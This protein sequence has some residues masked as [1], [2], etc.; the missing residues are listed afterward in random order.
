MLLSVILPIYNVKPY[1]AQCLNSFLREQPLLQE[2]GE[3]LLIDD[4]STDDSGE[5][6]ESYARKYPF[7]RVFHQPN[8]GAAAARNL[9]MR[10]ARGDWLWFVDA[11][12]WIAENGVA[13]I[14]NAAAA[15]PKAD[16]ILF[17]AFQNR[18]KQEKVWEHFAKPALFRTRHNMEILQRMVLYP[19]SRVSM[20]APW[21]KIYR[22]SFLIKNRLSFP[23]ELKVLDD[24]AFNARVFG[25]AETAAYCKRRIYHYRYVEQSITRRYAPDRLRLDREVWRYLFGYAEETAEGNAITEADNVTAKSASAEAW[26]NACACRIVKSFAIC[27]RL[28]FFHPDNPKKRREKIWDMQA[29]LALPEYRWA[30]SR[31]AFSDVEWKLK[32]LLLLY[33]LHLPRGIALLSLAETFVHGR[34]GGRIWARRQK[35]HRQKAGRRKTDMQKA[36]QSGTVLF[37][38]TKEASY[39]RNV[40]EIRLLK[41]HTAACHV[42]ASESRSYPIRLLSVYGRL[43]FTRMRRFDIVFAGFAPQLVLP[44]W[45][46]KFRHKKLVVDFFISCYDTLCFDR[47]KFQPES[48]AGR[49]LYRLDRATLARADEVYCDT[50]A[51]ADY[52]VRTFGIKKEKCHVLYL[53]ADR[54]IYHPLGL[55]RP[56]ALRDR[57]VVLYFGSGLPLQGTDVVLEAMRLFAGDKRF[58][59]LYIGPIREKRL[60]RCRPMADNIR[61]IPWA[62]QQ[63]LAAWID[64]SDLCLAGHFNADIDKASRVIPGKAYLYQAMEK[65][66]ILGDNAA[67]REVFRESGRIRFVEMGNAGAL[68][69]GIEGFAGARTGKGVGKEGFLYADTEFT[70]A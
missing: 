27:C 64:R 6:A 8:G 45:Q 53:E 20:A 23:E 26:Q 10:K 3:L 69:E 48:A 30:F 28:C 57:L 47:Q 15:H 56:K 9:G 43:L 29:A 52:L 54:Q 17:D 1:L 2:H 36:D 55:P 4:G 62:T 32:V 13:H 18:G 63:E 34:R 68:A 19:G 49:L 12:D 35:T 38:T 7:L 61:C 14:L 59:F 42:I 58:Y 39:I 51:H 46:W 21:D 11:D 41:E 22:H 44:L 37:V 25:A 40:Q 50:A 67:N 5:M 60:K 33:R 65:P 24:M 16:V 31:A 70:P 66:M